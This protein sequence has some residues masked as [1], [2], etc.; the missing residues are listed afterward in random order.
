MV[1]DDVDEDMVK[2]SIDLTEFSSNIYCDVRDLLGFG[3][4]DVSCWF[5]IP[6]PPK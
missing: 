2:R 5:W 1:V 3:D 4:L 6:V